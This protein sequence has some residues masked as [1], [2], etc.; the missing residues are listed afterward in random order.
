M[1]PGAY[2]AV[3]AQGVDADLVS[4]RARRLGLVL[5]DTVLVIQEDR[6]SFVLLF[7]SP[8]GRTVL[9]DAQ[10]GLGALNVRACRVGTYVNPRAF[11]GYERTSRAVW[12]M[13]PPHAAS[14]TGEL[15]ADRRYMEAGGTDFA[16]KPGIRG[17]DPSGRWPPNVLLVDG[18]LARQLDE[19]HGPTSKG[20]RG[21][22][23]GISAL[24]YGDDASVSRFFPRL[25][26]MAEV[27]AWVARLLA[28]PRGSTETT[29]RFE[30]TV[31]C[32]APKTDDAHG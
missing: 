3:F 6:V 22:D 2:F 23:E 31:A 26:N 27:R 20:V 5:R 24:G 17:G 29:R 13:Q 25:Q 4:L 10:L 7:R 21:S 11:D 14:R 18:P 30:P 8:S 12:R 16:L 15:S 32:R 19:V 28:G 1:R 9:E